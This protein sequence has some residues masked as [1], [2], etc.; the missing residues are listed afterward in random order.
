MFVPKDV[1]YS[2]LL[3]ICN[4]KIEDRRKLKGKK[5]S[6]ICTFKLLPNYTCLLCH[7]KMELYNLLNGK[8]FIQPTS[9][10]G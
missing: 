4:S 8:A 9:N 6:L 5:K 10:C 2:V 7:F 3:R 1:M